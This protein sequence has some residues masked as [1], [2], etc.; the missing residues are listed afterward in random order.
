ME[1]PPSGEGSAAA[2]VVGRLVDNLDEVTARTQRVLMEEVADL[3]GDA[4]LV[5]LLRD[6]VAANIDTVLSAI[7]HGI[8]VGHVEAPTAALEYARRLAQRDVSANALVRAYRIGHQAVLKIL[9]EEIRASDLDPQRRLDVFDEILAVTFRYI[10][11]ITQQVLGVYQ[12]EYDRWQQSRNRLQAAE[13]RGVLE[14]DDDVDVDAVSTT[15]RYPLR[16]T[17]VGLVLWCDASGDQDELSAME[18]YVHEC[19]ASVGARERA[20]FVSA[21]RLTAWAWLPVRSENITLAPIPEDST[22]HVVAGRALPGVAGFRRSHRQ[23]QLARRVMLAAGS[24]GDR[25]VSAAEPGLML[26]GLAGTDLDEAR[27]W[28]AAVLGPL[29]TASPGDERLRET[30]RVFLRAGSSF[31]AAAG[32]LHLHFNSVKYRVQRAAER[33]GRPITDDRLDVEVALLLCHWFGPAILTE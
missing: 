16:A 27:A 7:R 22:L 25:P 2:D 24:P 4:Q 28:V 13:I 17:H 10:D 33:R 14:S 1:I 23:A 5:Q 18:R 21:D 29:A 19:A 30:L 3:G 31:K 9:L 12:D 15:L 32:E 26:A 20:L 6:N 8:P 11:W